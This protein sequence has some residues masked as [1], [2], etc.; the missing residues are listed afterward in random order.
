MR[1]F[2]DGQFYHLHFVARKRFNVSRRGNAQHVINRF[3][4]RFFGVYDHR[5]AEVFFYERKVFLLVILVAAYARYRVPRAHSFRDGARFHIYLV[6]VG[7]SDEYI[8]FV[9]ARFFKFGVGYAFI[10]YSHNVERVYNVFDDGGVGIY[11]K[12]VVFFVE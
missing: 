1:V 3:R 8:G 9:Y 10:A 7:H 2:A 12:H 4:R 5:N 11:R 6:A